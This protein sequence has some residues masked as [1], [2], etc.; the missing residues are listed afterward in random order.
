M[1]VFFITKIFFNMAMGASIF[2]SISTGDIGILNNL[3]AQGMQSEDVAKMMTGVVTAQA[4]V[5][6]QQ[7]AQQKAE[8]ERRLIIGVGVT[9]GIALFSVIVFL[10]NKKI[11]QS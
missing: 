10:I 3:G 8:R 4:Q 6:A 5:Q 1:A 9:T 11:Q 2:D 7:A